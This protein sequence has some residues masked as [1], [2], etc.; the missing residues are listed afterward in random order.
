VTSTRR[1]LPPRSGVASPACPTPRMPGCGI[2]RGS[3]SRTW[4]TSATRSSTFGRSARTRAPAMAAA[5]AQTYGGPQPSTEV[6]AARGKG[7]RRVAARRRWP[8]GRTMTLGELAEPRR[9]H[10]RTAEFEGAALRLGAGAAKAALA[11]ATAARAAARATIQFEGTWRCLGAAAP[12]PARAVPQPGGAPLGSQERMAARGG[13]VPWSGTSRTTL[14]RW[15]SAL[16]TMRRAARH[17]G[18][19]RRRIAWRQS[20]AASPRGY[21]PNRP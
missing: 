1:T 15:P 20:G 9:L 10:T 21:L 4:A 13:A 14:R 7:R 6:Q 17:H 12:R 3:I 19:Y 5:P 16:P 8:L 2:R 11:N 18:D